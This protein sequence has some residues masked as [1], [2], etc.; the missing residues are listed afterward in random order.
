MEN[1][2]I[3]I[4]KP[5]MVST[6]VEGNMSGIKGGFLR[7]INRVYAYETRLWIDQVR[8]NGFSIPTQK[9]LISL[10]LM[11]KNLKLAGIWQQLDRMWVFATEL[12]GHAQISIVNPNHST[13]CAWPTNITEVNSPTWTKLKGYTG[14]GS[15]MYLNTNYNPAQ[16]YVNASVYNTSIGVYSLT[17]SQQ[18][19]RAD[20]GA[21]DNTSTSF[22][23]INSRSTSNQC[24][25]DI[26][27]NGSPDLLANNSSSLGLLACERTSSSSLLAYQNGVHL[28]SSGGNTANANPTNNNIY[29]LCINDNGSPNYYGSRQIAMTFFGSGGINQTT[30][31]N[32]FQKFATRIGFNV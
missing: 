32:I 15:S 4:P 22:W 11:I 12:K 14:N 7:D 16:N 10:D 5:R 23:W 27:D 17:N 18:N 1:G 26:N 25:M 24:V 29:I 2:L 6:Q 3:N 28:T 19:N 8:Q 20:V 13:A 21:Y 30:F 9:Y 31:Y